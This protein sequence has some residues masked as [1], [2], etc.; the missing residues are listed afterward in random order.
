MEY[1]AGPN[2]ER[3]VQ[4]HGA[5]PIGM[6]CEIIFQA[7]NGLQHAHDKGMVHRDIKPAN[8]LLHQEPGTETI[9]VKILDFGLARLQHTEKQPA[10]TI[11]ARENTV[12]GTPDFLSPEQSKDLHETDIRS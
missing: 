8:L 9:Q 4:K 2:L 1:V 11:I 12:M 6:A 10:K 5:L 7:A 3:Y